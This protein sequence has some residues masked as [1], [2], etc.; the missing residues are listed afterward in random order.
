MQP[1]SKKIRRR[2]LW[3]LLFLF[4]VLTPILIG[5][6]KGYRLDD[7]L[8]LIQTGGVYIHSDIANTYVF[9][10][11]E[12]VENNGAFLKNTL[13]QNLLPNRYYSIRVQREGYQDWA[14]V[15]AVK[16]NLVTEGRVMM[17]PT[18]FDWSIIY[19]TTTLSVAN[20]ADELTVTQKVINPEYAELVKLFLEEKGQFDME[21]ATSTY[22]YIRGKRRS[23]TTTVVETQFPDWLS[24]IASTSRLTSKDMVREREGIVTWLENGDLFAVWARKDDPAPYYFCMETCIDSFAINWSEDIIR[25]EFY[26]NRN[27]VLLVLTKSGLYAVELDGRSQRNIQIILEGLDMD[28]RIESGSVLVVRN[29]ESYRKTNL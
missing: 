10:D 29:G 7:A 26:P 16:P 15:L 9:M 28:F 25:Y 5:F 4:V 11:D 3:V 2:V 17:M 27:D 14:K 23:T 1:L 20:K 6:S 19:S 8:V 22:E 18:K 12:F 21:V 13:I 24:N